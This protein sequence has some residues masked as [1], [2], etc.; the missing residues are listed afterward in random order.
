MAKAKQIVIKVED[1][2]GTVAAAIAALAEAGVN[3]MSIYGSSPQGDLQLVVDNP[4]KAA[5][6]LAAAGTAYS[7]AKAEVVEL[8]NKPGSLHAYL[9]KLARKGV[10][11]RSISATSS[12]GARKSVVVWTADDPI[13]GNM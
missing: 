6:A 9:Q 12:K 4:R 11:L 13:S 2:P 5:K 1:R 7:E 10:N 3:I 8:P